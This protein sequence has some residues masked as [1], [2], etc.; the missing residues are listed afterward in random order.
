MKIALLAKGPSTHTIK[1]AQFLQKRGNK[2]YLLSLEP[3]AIE[4]IEVIDLAPP[5]L[6]FKTGYFLVLNK[7]K[8]LIK[9]INPDLLH[10]HY[11]S[12]YGFLGALSRFH[13][14]VISVWGSDVFDFPRAN[15]LN[16]LILKYALN[17]A[18]VITSTSEVMARETRKHVTGKSVLVV[19]FGI[20]TKLFHPIKK[21]NQGLII[22]TVR[23]LESK[24]G[25]EFLVKAFSTFQSIN[26]AARLYIVG[27]GSQLKHLR[28]LVVG[29]NLEEKVKFLG[30]L[31][32]EDVAKFLRTIDIFVIPSSSESFGVAALEASASGI[33]VIASRIGGLVET[34]K[35]SRTGVFFKPNSVADLAQKLQ[36]LYEDSALRK[37]LAVE[38]PRFVEEEFEWES[39]A[40]KMNQV[41]KKLVKYR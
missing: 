3:V 1:W 2:V 13:P 39:N 15:P 4:N 6:P 37:K 19:P 22:G 23:A 28:N 17:N 29:L 25:L 27:K 40:D 38:G 20:D 31:G 41:Y 14:Y 16:K 26:P 5:K 18:E 7:V 36:L 9:E 12:S 35:E 24:Y 33:P 21:E 30:P 32:Q 8:K 34:V 11:A 10:A